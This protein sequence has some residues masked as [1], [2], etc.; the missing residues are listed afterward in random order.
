MYRTGRRVRKI[1]QH[2]RDFLALRAGGPRCILITSYGESVMSKKGLLILAIAWAFVRV[3]GF[4]IRQWYKRGQGQNRD[5][6][7]VATGNLLEPR[8]SKQG[9][10]AE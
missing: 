10:V 2:G 6:Q 7:A 9:S 8:V 4:L 3:I 5:L 1:G